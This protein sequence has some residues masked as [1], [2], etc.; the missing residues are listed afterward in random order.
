MNQ[1]MPVEIEGLSKKFCRDLRRS[2]WY[3]VK[4]LTREILLQKAGRPDLRKH[5]FWALRDI[6]MEVPRGETLGLIGPNG[7]GKSTLL[8]M[9][10]GLMKP[11]VGTLQ[12]R[13]RVGALIELGMG[14]DPI[15]TGR[16]NAHINGAV[17]GISGKEM[18]RLLP[19]IIDFAELGDFIDAPVQTYSTG[20]K[21]R[22][23]FSVASH[24]SPDLLLVDEV[25]AVGDS[26]FRQRCY[27]HLAEFKRDGGTIIF[28][29]HNTTALQ[30]VSDRV[31]H[32]DHGRIVN[33]GAPADVIQKYE[34]DML[35]LS[36]QASVRLAKK[37]NADTP[38]GLRFTK[39]EYYDID[40]SAGA[41]FD[42]GEPLEIHAHYETDKELNSPYFIVALKQHGRDTSYIAWLS[43]QWDGVDLG[44]VPM[45]G[46]IRC[47]IDDPHLS[48]GSYGLHLGVQAQMSGHLGEKWHLRPRE[49]STLVVRPGALR[50]QFPGMPSGTLVSMP[51]LVTP[52][53][54]RVDSKDIA[55][56]QGS[57]TESQ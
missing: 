33:A 36:R 49:Y 42:F 52:H 8:K 19:D 21:V 57:G 28:V 56:Q 23:G 27:R 1:L 14:F 30:A 13:G 54:W 32:L 55:A 17:L 46:V 20:M 29:S 15:L 35:E 44:A 45:R 24:L 2:L 25:L 12:I 16:E 40:G 41:E 38:H 47:V 10:N 9:V 18:S 26:S 43:M 48:P 5:E 7:A 4:D 51:Y 34:Q 6:T 53:S 31:I 3:G 22:L 39:V 37:N 50:S 11:D